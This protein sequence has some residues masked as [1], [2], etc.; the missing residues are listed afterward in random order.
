MIKTICIH[1]GQVSTGHSV[2]LT[3]SLCTW[4]FRLIQLTMAYLAIP[5]EHTFKSF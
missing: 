1:V 5:V 4:A 2:T 3:V